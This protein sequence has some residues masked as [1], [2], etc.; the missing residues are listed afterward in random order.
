MTPRSWDEV[1]PLNMRM[2]AI[3]L[4]AL[5][6]T[7][8][9]R[10]QPTI[11]E[12][13]REAVVSRWEFQKRFP[14]AQK[15]FDNQA[16]EGDLN[17]LI[18]QLRPL[19]NSPPPPPKRPRPRPSP[20][21]PR[22]RPSPPPGPTSPWAWRRRRPRPERAKKDLAAAARQAK[23]NV[24]V[25]YEMA[26]IL[27][28]TGLVPARPHLAAGGPPRHAGKRVC[29]RARSGQD[30]IVEGARDHAA[31]PVPGGPAR[32]GIRAP[33]GSVQPLGAVPG[34]DAAPARAI[35]HGMGP[36]ARLALRR[37]HLPADAVL[38]RSIPVPRQPLALP[39]PGAGHLR[40][41]GPAGAV[42]PPFP[43]HRPSLGRKDAP[44]GG[45]ARA[46]PGRGTGAP[47]PAGGRRRVRAYGSVLAPCC[48]G[49]I[50]PRTRNPCSRAF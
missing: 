23:G 12:S 20:A 48:F 13:L 21:V 49:S 44:G 39:A 42:R 8:P 4:F 50:V 14:A 15:L 36:G 29:A 32:H 30:G 47:E 26:R 5:A 25:N 37:R 10:A 31:G 33:P 38:R 7:A 43:A 24:G 2:I 40:R 34:L 16:G 27:G 22:N 45:D 19:A 28:V 6:A 3:I 41:R 1:S 17:L 46:L 35:S 9:L 18:G 11:L